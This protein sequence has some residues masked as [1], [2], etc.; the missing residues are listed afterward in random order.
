MR[1]GWINVFVAA[2]VMPATLR[3]GPR[4]WLITE[5]MMHDLRLDRVSYANLNLWATLIGAI[6]CLPAGRAV[7][8]PGGPAQRDG[9]LRQRPTRPLA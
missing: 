6:T 3:G 5:P 1:G 9:P 8:R 4:G 2:V 7:A